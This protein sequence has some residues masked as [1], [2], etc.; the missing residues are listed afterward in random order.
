MNNED[1]MINS[2]LSVL[3]NHSESGEALD[4]A[5][6]TTYLAFDCMCEA[7]FGYQLRAV[8]GSEE[9]KKKYNLLYDIINMRVKKAILMHKNSFKFRIIFL[10]S[11]LL[12]HI[13]SFQRQTIASQSVL[14]N[15]CSE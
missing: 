7:A 5:A 14:T 15:G 6:L 10:I 4:L 12:M 3:K 11:R 13:L 9:G 8:N 2:L 1:S